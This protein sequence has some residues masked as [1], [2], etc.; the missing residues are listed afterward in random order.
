MKNKKIFLDQEEEESIYVGLVRLAKPLPDYEVFFHLNNHN[1]FDFKRTKDVQLHG[2]YNDYTFTR[3]EAYDKN[4]ENC[5]RIISNKSAETIIKKEQESLFH[6]EEEMK[7]LLNNHQDV[8]YIITASDLYIDFSLILLPEK[9]FFP[10][11]EFLL[12]PEEELYQIIQY[13]E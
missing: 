5:W 6:H 2:E 11:Q 9:L 13:Y 8:D 10:I 4:T 12:E 7:F 3:F 1:L